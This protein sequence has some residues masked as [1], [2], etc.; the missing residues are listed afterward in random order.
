MYI[1]IYI[2]ACTVNLKIIWVY[3]DGGVGPM[4]KPYEREEGRE[5][6]HSYFLILLSDNLFLYF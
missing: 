5:G 1:Y 3:V 6:E 2:N 4:K